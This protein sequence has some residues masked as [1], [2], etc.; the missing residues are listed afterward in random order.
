MDVHGIKGGTDPA[1]EAQ[2]TG[3][4]LVSPVQGDDPPGH[5]V[6][7]RTGRTILVY[8]SEQINISL[9]L[10]LIP[11]KS[12]GIV[13]SKRDGRTILFRYFFQARA[14]ST[15]ISHTGRA[16]WACRP[17]REEVFWLIGSFLRI[18][19]GFSRMTTTCRNH[20]FRGQYF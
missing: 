17:D 2:K 16:S 8:H 5:V 18:Y 20:P 13:S 3:Q 7:G 11:C 4:D 6:R 10:Q 14:A 15:M 12:E 9:Q 1:G 19:A